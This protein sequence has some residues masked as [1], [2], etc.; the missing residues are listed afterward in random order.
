MKKTYLAITIGPVFKTIQRARKTRELWA[1]SFILSQYMRTLL[2]ALKDYG[3]ALSPDITAGKLSQKF[4]GAGIWNDNCFF[5][6]HD[7]QAPI[8]REKLQDI[9]TKA[10]ADTISL[11]LMEDLKRK[12]K[13]GRPR[14]RRTPR[15]R[16]GQISIGNHPDPILALPCGTAGS[17]PQRSVWRRHDF[18]PTR[19]NAQ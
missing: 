17:R 6:L 14:S 3:K 4:R 1:A 9:L 2:L 13:G 15:C 11:L 18:A 19:Q 8:L 5:E 7:D 16:N 12:K 10:K